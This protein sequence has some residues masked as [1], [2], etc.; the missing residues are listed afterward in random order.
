MLNDISYL[1]FGKFSIF[2]VSSRCSGCPPPS[3]P[4]SLV[5]GN[6]ELTFH[7]QLQQQL[8][9]CHSLLQITENHQ[10]VPSCEFSK[11]PADFSAN[12]QELAG[13][14]L[15]LIHLRERFN[16]SLIDHHC[17]LFFGILFK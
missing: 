6:A 15:G 5:K 8:C 17:H 12:L 9:H 14:R 13:K 4:L 10:E 3:P 2:L 7:S 16:K 11:N 1:E